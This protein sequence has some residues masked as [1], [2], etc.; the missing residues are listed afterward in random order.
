MRIRLHHDSGTAL[1]ANA[2]GSGRRRLL[3]GCSADGGGPRPAARRQGQRQP[4]RLLRR[5][6]DGG[7]Q[8]Q[9]REGSATGVFHIEDGTWVTKDRHA[10]CAAGTIPAD[11]ADLACNSN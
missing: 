1:A 4:V 8:R 7:Y 6:G 11:I 2:D 5:M 3:A 10:E 9:R